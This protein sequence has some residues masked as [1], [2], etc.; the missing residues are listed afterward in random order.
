MKQKILISTGGSGGHVV[1][2]L[3]IFE[4][5]KDHFDVF[6][7]SDLRGSKFIESNVYNYKII[8]VSPLA[9]SLLLPWNIILL[10]LSGI[11]GSFKS[12]LRKSA[13]G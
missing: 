6:L 8:N 13:T 1:P 11:I 5:L 10:A 2:A 4:H 7:C 3:T 12:N 9:N